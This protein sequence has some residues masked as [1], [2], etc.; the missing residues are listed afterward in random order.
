MNQAHLKYHSPIPRKGIYNNSV[1]QMSMW[2]SEVY[3]FAT[4]QVYGMRVL[5]HIGEM[6]KMSRYM[7]LVFV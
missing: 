1:K 5:M 6:T 7:Q 3:N 2:Y 4:Q